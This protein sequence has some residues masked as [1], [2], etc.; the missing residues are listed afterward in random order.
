MKPFRHLL[1]VALLACSCATQS[2]PVKSAIFIKLPP[3][4]NTVVCVSASEL[5]ASRQLIAEFSMQTIRGSDQSTA[6][7]VLFSRAKAAGATHVFFKTSR[8]DIGGK[9]PSANI[10][11]T[12]QSSGRQDSF[13]RGFEA[14]MQSSSAAA[15]N[16][17]TT[18]FL[19]V[20]EAYASK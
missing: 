11:I 20:C 7:A 5:P 6:K 4:E 2:D 1:L 3:S 18:R 13:S 8:F 10:H 19:I 15:A 12:P 14:G 17:P 9:T 16:Q